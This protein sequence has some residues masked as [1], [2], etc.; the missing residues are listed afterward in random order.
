MTGSLQITLLAI[1]AFLLS[2]T[3]WGQGMVQ[4][5]FGMAPGQVHQGFPGMLQEAPQQCPF[6]SE[7]GDIKS[8]IQK[9]RAELSQLQNLKDKCPKVQAAAAS[10]RNAL[11]D[12][13]E[14]ELPSQSSEINCQNYRGAYRN[15]LHTV[16]RIKDLKY[17]ESADL[18]MFQ[19]CY[20][21]IS[22]TTEFKN[23]TEDVYKSSI[24]NKSRECKTKESTYFDNRRNS[25][26][27]TNIIDISQYAENL[28]RDSEDCKDIA[29]D[30]GNNILQ[31]GIGALSVVS[32]LAPIAGPAG[33]LAS[34]VGQ[35]TAALVDRFFNRKSPAEYIKKLKNEEKW[36]DLNCIY[37]MVQ[38]EN[39]SCRTLLH[40]DSPS[41][42]KGDYCPYFSHEDVSIKAL[43]RDIQEIV[44]LSVISAPNESLIN[45]KVDDLLMLLQKKVKD[46]LEEN[47][48]TSLKEY[49]TKVKN[50][51]IEAQKGPKKTFERKRNVDNLEKF[52]AAYSEVEKGLSGSS[53][54]YDQSL[55][56][57]KK[58]LS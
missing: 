11:S 35:I 45:E 56:D 43:S 33:I 30:I 55:M 53:E 40:T 38:K 20:S 29:G 17:V 16:L 42:G 32:S 25:G 1:V 58:S 13:L 39:L 37:Y 28:I 36:T 14:H 2:V 34:M 46:P 5:G 22:N 47:K 15:Q 21:E 9:T 26:L 50:G 6:S 54:D 23:C 12:V 7:S 24:V 8:I 18:G 44:D 41:T 48:E 19:R 51:L 31:S 27:Q 57:F 52:L 4:G 10:M 49:L 3:S